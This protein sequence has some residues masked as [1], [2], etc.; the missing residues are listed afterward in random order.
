MDIFRRPLLHHFKLII[1]LLL[2]QR[3]LSNSPTNDDLDDEL[4]QIIHASKNSTLW[5]TARSRAAR[6]IQQSNGTERTLWGEL[7]EQC[8]KKTSFSCVK[9]GMFR[10]LDRSLEV[11]DDVEMSEDLFFRRNSNKYNGVCE[12]S[13]EERE[14]CSKYYMERLSLLEG[15]PQK[16]EIPENSENTTTETGKPGLTRGIT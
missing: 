7:L 15:S 6:S 2:L 3:T 11:R 16:N 1:L 13:E 10:Y 12:N 8:S 14:R 5:T 9:T 4:Y